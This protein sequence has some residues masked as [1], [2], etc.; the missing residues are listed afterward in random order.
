M[1]KDEYDAYNI[2]NVNYTYHFNIY[3]NGNRV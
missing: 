1:Q 3:I 2:R